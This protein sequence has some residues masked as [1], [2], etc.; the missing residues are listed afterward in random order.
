MPFSSRQRGSLNVSIVRYEQP[1]EMI[2]KLVETVSFSAVI[3]TIYL[4]DNS[5]QKEEK[6]NTLPVRYIKTKKNI[7]FGRAHNIALQASMNENVPYHLI[8]NPDVEFDPNIL[9][10]IIN[11]LEENPTV[12]ALMPKI[13]Y[14]NG[15]LQYVCK[16]LPTPFDLMNR[17][18][19]LHQWFKK[20]ADRFILK[21]FN[22]ETILNVPYLSGCFMVLNMTAIKK[23]G[24]FDER[25]FLYPEDIDLSRRIHEHF[26]T[27]FFPKVSIIHHHEQ[28][29]YKNLHLLIIHIVNS[30]RYFNKWGW[31]FD[32]Q[33]KKFNLETLQQINKLEDQK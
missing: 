14:P 29:S 10:E 9:L 13:Y 18:F 7:G 12:G 1:F 19:I 3:N 24:F 31:F 17:R 23:V 27:I 16:L 20:K 6:F 4:I 15:S 22:Y 2:Q 21:H 30:I 25:F 26:Q 11:Y 28:G 32:P 8:L 5:K 33:R